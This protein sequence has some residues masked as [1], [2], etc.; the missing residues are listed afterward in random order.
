VPVFLGLD[1]VEPSLEAVVDPVDATRNA[2]VLRFEKPEPFLNL[3]HRRFEVADIAA[4]GSE[5]L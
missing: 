2:G 4:D 3:D 5:M 1:E